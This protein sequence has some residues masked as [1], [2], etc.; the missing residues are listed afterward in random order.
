MPRKAFKSKRMASFSFVSFR[1]VSFRFVS[2]RFVSFRFVSFRFVS[3]RFVS[4]RFVSFHTTRQENEMIGR[5]EQR[6]MNVSKLMG[7]HGERD[8]RQMVRIILA[9]VLAMRMII[10]QD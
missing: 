7:Q 4:F 5:M 6:G 10:M 8:D 3:F 1:L 9:S 2:F